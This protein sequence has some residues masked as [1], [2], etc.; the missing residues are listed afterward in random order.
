MKKELH[1]LKVLIMQLANQVELLNQEIQT[2]KQTNIAEVVQIVVSML[3][4][5][6]NSE[7]SPQALKEDQTLLSCDHCEIKSKLPPDTLSRIEKDLEKLPKETN[8]KENFVNCD[9]CQ[10]KC[11]NEESMI[12][13]M[14]TEHEECH[15]WH[16][17]EK[18]FGTKKF[19]KDHN[20]SKHKE[21]HDTTESEC[22]DNTQL[23]KH[24]KKV[25]QKKKNKRSNN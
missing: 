19:L 25:K 6:N 17:C 12:T 4:N 2:D 3:D 20:S 11:E 15:F 16:F 7:K 24:V 1:Q 5:A 22:E 13:H 9:N 21:L 14:S 8:E 10:F 23:T 18:Y